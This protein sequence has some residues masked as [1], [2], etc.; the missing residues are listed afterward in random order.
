MNYNDLT[1]TLKQLF[2]ML[3]HEQQLIYLDRLEEIV[4]TQ[5]LATVALSTT[6]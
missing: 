4:N 6:D 3:D 2:E 5:S 1:E